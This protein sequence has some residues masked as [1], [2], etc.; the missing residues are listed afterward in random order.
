MK[1]FRKWSVILVLTLSSVC[2]LN[3]CK[4]KNSDSSETDVSS[5]TTQAA[6]TETAAAASETTAAADTAAPSIVIDAGY[7][8]QSSTSGKSSVQYPVL[9]DA[10]DAVNELIQKNAQSILDAY[11]L[12]DDD[13]LTMTSEVLAQD[14]SRVTVI[15]QGTV[16]QK[17]SEAVNIFCSNTV[18]LNKAT[19]IT[20]NDFA[21]AYTLAGYVLSDDCYFTNLDE[22]LSSSTKSELMKEKNSLSI[23]QYTSLFEEADFPVSIDPNTLYPGSFS[24]EKDGVI[25]FTIPVSHELGDY[26]MVTYAPETK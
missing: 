7:S 14:K 3:G 21:D 24:F 16:T 2:L 11:E 22:S 18:D 19:N 5:T 20:L 25:Y 13:T 1:K 17:G 8:F 9:D 10:S 23:S 15:Y 4:K 12:T 26:A 6:A